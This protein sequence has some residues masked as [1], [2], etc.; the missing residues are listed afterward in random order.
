VGVVVAFDL[1]AFRARYP[2]FDYVSDALVD[3]Y[4]AEATGYHA[5][6]G[7][8][9]VKTAAL[10]SLYLNMMTAHIAAL[11]APKG[12]SGDPANPLVGRIASAGEGSVNVS[13]E[14]DGG[15][16]TTAWF[17]Q[18]RYGAAYLQATQQYRTFR[19]RVPNPPPLDFWPP[20]GL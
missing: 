4:F 15:S 10:Q 8:G 2:E 1:A 7:S 18:T 5:N 3:Q 6:D 11:N 12:A 14:Y 13:A 16:I 9:P 20:P 17:L 19:Y